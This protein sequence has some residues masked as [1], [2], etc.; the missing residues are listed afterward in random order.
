MSFKRRL[1]DQQINQRNFV[2]KNNK[3]RGGPHVKT[4][5]AHRT[6]LKRTIRC[7]FEDLFSDDLD[8]SVITR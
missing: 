5:K 4:H 7:E 2:A 1:E 6:A 8:L 3:H